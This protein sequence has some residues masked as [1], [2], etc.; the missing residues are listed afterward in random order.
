MIEPVSLI[1]AALF[2]GA[3]KAAGDIAP[4]IY[5]GFKTLIKRKFAGEPKAETLLEEY[6]KDPKLA[7]G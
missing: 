3:T 2:A 5:S 7:T 4:D 1:L 6:E